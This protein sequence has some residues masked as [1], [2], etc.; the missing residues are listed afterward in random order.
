M[1]IEHDKDLT[2]QTTFHVPAGTALYAEYSSAG[3]LLTLSRTK[4]FIENEVLSIGGGSN[5]LFLNKFRGMVIHSAITGI[6][7]YSKDDE[8]VFV[9]AGAGES[10][11][12]LVQWC[13]E[14]DIA[15][16]ENMVGI[17][18][19]VG[20]SA[21][22]NVGAYGAEAGD[23]IH[24]VECF[25]VDTRKTLILK[26]E[27]CRFGYRDSIF[28]HEAKGK[29]IV[30]RVSYRLR[31]SKLAQ[32]LEYAPLKQYAGELGRTPTLRELAGEIRR[33]RDSKLPNPDLIGSA[34]SFFKNPVLH[35]YF[36][37]EEIETRGIDLSP[38]PVSDHL[39][40]ISAARLIDMAGLK[41]FQIGGATVW[42][43]QPLVIANTGDATASDVAKLAKHVENVVREK[44]GITL[45]PEV[46]YIDSEIKITILGSGTSKGV[47]EIGCTC[48]AC[49]SDDPKDRR[50]RASVLVETQGLKLL[51]DASPDFRQQ[52]IRNDINSLDA[53]LLTHQ[54]YDHVGGIDD[55][56]PLCADRDMPI[57]ANRQTASDLRKRL[58]YC[59]RDQRYPGVP[60]LDLHEVDGYPFRI[61]GLKIT[62][63]EVMHGKLPV[64]GYRIGNFAY[65]TDAKTIPENEM[66]KLRGLDVLILNC[67]RIEKEHFAHIILPEAL[68]IIS[69]LQPKRCY[70][71]HSSHKMGR[72][73]DT[74][75]QLP[76]GVFLAYDNETIVIK[77]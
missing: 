16:L 6:Q 7:E 1:T 22:Q 50:L 42:P 13:I 14:R 75:K 63:I 47:P 17:P 4:E 58:D 38:Y 62:P 57:Y 66:E 70:L 59:F 52:A 26:N 27:E 37:E 40:K 64:Y 46:N 2:R 20:A 39:V 68:Q 5:L 73:A 29:Y 24:S 41:G 35:K 21:V 54:H 51:I 18:G 61:N 74:E 69:Q 36:Y 30:L 25:D 33:L 45:M 31:R 34:G 19:E 71:T 15:G 23:F 76:E 67:L 77:A 44:F 11:D 72:H 56:R 12:G 49:Q 10:W 60:G 8:N 53:V 3:E 65:I 32:N 28:K 43:G 48:S 9:I 55:L